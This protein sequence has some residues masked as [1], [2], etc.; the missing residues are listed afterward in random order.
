M[1]LFFNLFMAILLISINNNISDAAHKCE[2]SGIYKGVHLP[3]ETWSIGSTYPNVKYD[4][5]CGI[6][7]FKNGF[8]AFQ[9]DSED[10]ICR[11]ISLE[12]PL[13]I[14]V[15]PENFPQLKVSV[16]SNFL[17]SPITG[18]YE[19]QLKVMLSATWTIVLPEIQ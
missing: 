9:H 1:R 16:D 3:E 14:T 15:V 8:L 17:E 10:Q 19:S 6:I 12:N 2:L 18:G 7:A 5:I 13:N 11:L 4:T